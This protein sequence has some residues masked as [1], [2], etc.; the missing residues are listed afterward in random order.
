[1]LKAY[2]Q[3]CDPEFFF[4]IFSVLLINMCEVPKSVPPQVQFITLSFGKIEEQLGRDVGRTRKPRA[5]QS[6]DNFSW[7]HLAKDR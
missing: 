3:D 5:V 2:S 4:T 1:M 6:G 7:Y